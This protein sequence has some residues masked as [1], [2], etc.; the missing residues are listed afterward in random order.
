MTYVPP[1]PIGARIGHFR[2]V[3]G[4]PGFAL[5]PPGFLDTN[6]LV[7]A[8]RKSGIEG[9]AQRKAPIQGSSCCGGI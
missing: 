8:T 3:L 1:S 6:M 4:L 7:S 9:I 2:L 5:G